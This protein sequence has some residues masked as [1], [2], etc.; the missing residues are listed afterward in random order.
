MSNFK[1]NDFYRAM[2]FLITTSCKINNE[3]ICIASLRNLSR[4]FSCECNE[5]RFARFCIEEESRAEDPEPVI[6]SF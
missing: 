4:I 2:S 5:R 6:L 1:I 3:T